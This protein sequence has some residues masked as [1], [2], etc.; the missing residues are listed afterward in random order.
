MILFEKTVFI[1]PIPA[2]C[3]ELKRVKAPTPPGRPRGGEYAT[4]RGVPTVSEK[5]DRPVRL[6]PLLLPVL[7]LLFAAAGCGTP[8]PD[9]LTLEAPVELVT[10]TPPPTR[11][12]SP[13]PHPIQSPTA[14]PTATLTPTVTR[15][16]NPRLPTLVST[17]A[18]PPGTVDPALLTQVAPDAADHL[19]GGT[20]LIGRSVEGRAILARRFGQG[21]RALLLVGGT[22]G[23]WEVNTVVLMNELI[24]YFAGQPEAVAP[25][26]AIEIIPALNPD[27]LLRGRT[28][29]G[30]MNARNVDLNRNWS[31]DWAAE[32]IWQ[33]RT[34]SGG[35]QP[36]SEP[37]SAALAD[38][39]LF[40]QPVAVLF[41]HSA[42][43][44]VFPGA[45]EGDHGSQVLGRYYGTAAAYP[46]DAAWTSY[47]VTGDASNWVDGQGIASITV[48]LQTW[49]ESEFDRNLAG[50]MAVQ[51]ELARRQIDPT[52]QR[53]VSVHCV[54]VE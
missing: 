49:T 46:S 44:G 37:E 32:A 30:R 10:P 28:P 4:M 3:V 42:A 27:G 33:D 43:G 54:G 38:H 17:D 41:Y 9:P 1:R 21:T 51:C 19:P 14:R 23:G 39:I 8:P 48:E 5:G 31:C 36:F 24:T 13:T 52:T 2:I 11:R 40:S 25:G 34:V 12:P 15:T 18:P 29:E 53:W 16:P 50:I 26:L 22:H 7:L 45:C 35:E 47:E 6:R 20:S